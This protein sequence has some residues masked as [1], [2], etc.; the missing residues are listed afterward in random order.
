MQS[1]NIIIVILCLLSSLGL[2]GQQE[3]GLY[4]QQESWQ[5]NKL[6]PAFFPSGKKVIIGLPGLHSNAFISNFRL[7]DIRDTDEEGREVFNVNKAI[8][9]LEAENYL[10]EHLNFE[11]LS[12]GISAGRFHFSL[13]HSFNFNGYTKYPKTLP[14]LVWEGNSQFIGQDV[15]FGPNL[16]LT[17]YH[18]MAFGIGYNILPNVTLAGRFKYLSGIGDVSTER[19]SLSLFTD[20]DAYELVLTSDFLMNASGL[21]DYTSLLDLSIDTDISG[22]ITNG[23]FSSNSG[24]AL[25]LGLHAILGKLDIAASV[26]DLGGSIDWKETPENFRLEGD[27]AFAGLDALQSLLDDSTSIGSVLD[28]LESLYEPEQSFNSYSNDLPLRIYFGLGYQLNERW[29]VSGTL[30]HQQFRDENL[31]AAAVGLQAKVAGWLTAGVSYAYRNESYDNLG[32]NALFSLGSAQLLLASDNVLA[33]LQLGDS[34]GA[35]LRI[36]LNL[37]FGSKEKMHWNEV[38]NTEDFFNNQ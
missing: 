15:S 2:I 38:E 31:T 23:F 17:G 4:F 35:N 26:L 27:R 6:N 22:L 25:D 1:K 24:T 32:L 7:D 11:T 10:R 5:A 19:E 30:Y 16:Q 20:P 3:L 36:G 12:L 14:E 34:Y 18:E 33:P 8:D 28:T 9:Q 37:A 21:L 29:K 13:A